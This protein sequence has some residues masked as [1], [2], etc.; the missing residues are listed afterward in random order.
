LAEAPTPPDTTAPATATVQPSEVVPELADAGGA[1]D[2]PPT[3]APADFDEDVY[4]AVF[5]DIEKAVRAGELESGLQHYLRT[6]YRERRLDVATYRK[7]L[8]GESSAG[9]P[10][11]GVDVALITPGGLCYAWGW[12][13]DSELAPLRKI[14]VSSGTELLGSTPVVARCRRT[15]AAVGDTTRQKLFGFWTLFRLHRVPEQNKSVTVTLVVGNERR[16]YE[17]P[18]KLV[19]EQRLR[20]VVL[21]RLDNA[22][23]LGDPIIEG[24]Y[25]LDKGIGRSLIDL[26]SGIAARNAAGSCRMRFGTRRAS[27]QGSVIVC[28]DNNPDNLMLQ[29]AFFSQCP[30]YDRYEF[31]YVSN[32]PKLADRLVQEATIA[33]R[34]YGMAL[35]LIVLPGDAGCGLAYNIGVAAAESDRLLLISP[36]IMPRDMGWP[37]RH[38]E[39]VR[40]LPSEQTTIFGVTLYYGDGSLMH[41]GIHFEI[42]GGFSVRD[43][44][45]VRRDVLRVAHSGRGSPP[46]A[47]RFRASRRVPAVTGAFVSISRPWFEQL[48]GF[49]P[50]YVL[51]HSGDVDLCLRSFE[52]GTPVWLHD[53]PFSYL[54]AKA[55]SRPAP[56]AIMLVNQWL[57]TSRWGESVKARLNG[58]DPPGL[59]G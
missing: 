22:V 10:G 3:V 53:L 36:C 40:T 32:N 28:L 23:Y 21:D 16:S 57:L 55:S 20:N 29:A 8:I 14:V 9:L 19:S 2:A 45:V 59:G 46:E 24:F 47:V 33:N 6:G 52:A 30:G 4:L 38:A 31:I 37:S 56:G 15:D 11:G 18:M 50:E 41:G 54:E 58:L 1:I 34:I 42:D 5:P 13:D 7:T 51:D 17:R 49:S 12:F 43:S 48:G 27:Y 39:M 35:T 26:N 44:K 25:E